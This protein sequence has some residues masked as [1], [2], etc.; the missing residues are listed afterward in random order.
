MQGSHMQSGIASSDVT[1]SRLRGGPPSSVF[2][3]TVCLFPF[4]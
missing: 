3:L 4:I 2:S 1:G